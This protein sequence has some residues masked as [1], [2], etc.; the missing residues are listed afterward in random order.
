MNNTQKEF[1]NS[2]NYEQLVT[3]LKVYKQKLKDYNT[4]INHVEEKIY[5]K[6]SLG[7]RLMI[8]EYNALKLREKNRID[9]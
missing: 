8:E 3:Q 2:L 7:H 6:A 5:G 9:E 4:L 1:L